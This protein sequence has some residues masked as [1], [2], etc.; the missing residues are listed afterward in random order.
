MT[1]VGVWIVIVPGKYLAACQQCTDLSIANKS[2]KKIR[3]VL[4]RFSHGI[5]IL[6]SQS[7]S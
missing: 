1:R 5:S 7:S 3:F 4:K 6:S 2:L